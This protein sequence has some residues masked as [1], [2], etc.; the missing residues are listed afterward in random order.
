M[1]GSGFKE[2]HHPAMDI[3]KLGT[4]PVPTTIDEAALLLDE[5]LDVEEKRDIAT[6][7]KETFLLNAH[8]GLGLSIRNAFKLHSGN[9]ALVRSRGGHPDDASEVI[10]GALWKR[11]Q[12]L[13]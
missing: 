12:P 3:S 10:L 8:F 2:A 13:H 1:L 11:F 7:P 5:I 9:P 6:T 4:L